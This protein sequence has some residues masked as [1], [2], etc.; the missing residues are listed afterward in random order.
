ME[1]KKNYIV[2][3]N[4]RGKMLIRKRGKDCDEALDKADETPLITYHEDVVEHDVDICFDD[5]EEEKEVKG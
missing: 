4:V 1:K 3:A 5:V 2:E